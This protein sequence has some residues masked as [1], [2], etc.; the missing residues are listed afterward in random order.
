MIST[1]RLGEVASQS[2]EHADRMLSIEAGEDD[3]E[4]LTAPAR[5]R[6]F[7]GQRSLR[8]LREGAERVVTRLVAV[9]VVQLLEPVEICD[10]KRE[11]PALPDQVAKLG[12]E[13]PP[14]REAR[15]A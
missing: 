3:D 4:L 10:C 11:S 8:D 15:E 7:V 13:G 1:V 2:L 9:G 6:V 14:V 5:G 12:L